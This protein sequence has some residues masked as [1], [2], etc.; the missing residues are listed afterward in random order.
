[1]LSFNHKFGYGHTINS[2]D[3]AYD[4]GKF[5]LTE[6]MIEC[7][8]DSKEY[9]FSTAEIPRHIFHPQFTGIVEYKLKECPGIFKLEFQFDIPYFQRSTKITLAKLEGYEIPE[10]IE[11]LF[12]DEVKLINYV[13]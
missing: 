11:N 12:P 4:F 7:I 6:D 10:E 13:K 3:L 5:K 9:K 2:L 1:M 8:K